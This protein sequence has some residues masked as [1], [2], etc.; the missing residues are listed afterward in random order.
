MRGNILAIVVLPQST[1]IIQADIAGEPVGGQIAVY[2]SK[3][4]PADVRVLVHPTNDASEERL[5]LWPTVQILSRLEIGDLPQREILIIDSRA[6]VPEDL[7][8]RL[9]TEAR[10]LGTS[11]QLVASVPG[12]SGHASTLAIYLPPGSARADMFRADRV[13]PGTGLELILGESVFSRTTSVS[14]EDLG[15]SRP[16][17]LLDSYADLA[18]VEGQVLLT[19]AY[20]VM[21]RGVRVRDPHQVWL[22]GELLCGSDVELDVNVIV[23]GKVVLGDGVRI[24]ANCILR[25]SHVGANTRIQPFSL[26]ESAKIGLHAT[27]GPYARIRPISVIGDRVQIGNYVEI[28]NSEVG[29]GSRINHHAFVGDALLGDDVTIGAG[30]ITCNHDGVRINRTTIDQGAY[31][32]SGCNLVAPVRIG[33]GATVGAGSTITH[34]VPPATLTIARARQ[35]TIDSWRGTRRS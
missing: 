14:A 10:R 31:I 5:A 23:E 27:V 35:V 1:K 20:G 19:R 17:I 34:D 25:D 2:L 8:G 16:A 9:V 29:S 28:K 13:A 6:W 4:A 24:G 33:R 26:V 22:R 12:L 7:I 18:R 15:E 11:T 32:G 30:T 21:E 3:L